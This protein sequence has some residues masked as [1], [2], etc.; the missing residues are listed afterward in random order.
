MES[1]EDRPPT[2]KLVITSLAP[3]PILGAAELP[4][5]EYEDPLLPTR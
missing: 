4:L 2:V 3:L 1:F 5:R